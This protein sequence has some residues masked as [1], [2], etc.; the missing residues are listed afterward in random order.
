MNSDDKDIGEKLTELAG[1]ILDQVLDPLTNPSLDQQ[2]D[3][4]KAVTALHLGL[5]KARKGLPS[6]DEPG[7]PSLTEMRKKL[8]AVGES[9]AG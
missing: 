7:V 3:S 8:R 9:D 5:L 4:L 2:L 1:T 6:D